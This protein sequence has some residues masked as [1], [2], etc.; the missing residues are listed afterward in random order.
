MQLY[1]TKN[2]VE[3]NSPKVL[4]YYCSSPIMH[5]ALS[6]GELAI[7]KFIKLLNDRNINA[8][9]FSNTPQLNLTLFTN[10][11]SNNTVVVYSEGVNGNPLNAKRICRWM[12]YN[13]FI[14]CG[15][16]II[17]SW[18]RNDVLCSYGNY[19]CGLICNIRVDVVD[20]NEHIFKINNCDKSK[21]YFVVHKALLNGWTQPQLNI[22]IMKLK[23]FGF[24]EFIITKKDKMNEMMNQC[25]VFVSF[26]LNT[27][28]S[29]IAVLCGALSMIHKSETYNISYAHVLE[30]RGSYGSVGI[31]PFELSLLN[32]PYNYSERLYESN[33]YR[34][35][36]KSSNNINEFI[37]HFSL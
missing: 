28:I 30:N 11:I 13:P 6:G 25:S 37:N 26:D 10:K 17:N 33:L 21:K 34:E 29:N 14:R 35:Y 9:L 2:R 20:F 1:H 36:I 24:E 23:Q 3:D 4:F 22:E 7:L 19:D 5:D 15:K 8:K 31:K 32:S 27:Y 16:N 18:S 12:L